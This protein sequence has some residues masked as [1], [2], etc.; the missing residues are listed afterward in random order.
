MNLAASSIARGNPSTFAHIRP[1]VSA[2]R[3]VRQK[4]GS[5]ARARSVNSL[6]VSDLRCSTALPAAIG[7]GS[8][9]PASV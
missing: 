6:T 7:V 3:S 4:A 2:F 5:T 8:D 9:R 1:T